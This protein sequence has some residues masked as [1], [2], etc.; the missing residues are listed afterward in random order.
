MAYVIK[1]EVAD[2][3]AKRFA[4]AAQK[5]MYGGKDIAVGDTLYIIAS[6]THGG[7]GL[8]AKGTVTAVDYSAVAKPDVSSPVYGGGPPEGRGGGKRYTPRVSI[9]VKRTATAKRALGRDTLRPH[10]GK[11]GGKGELAMRLYKQATDKIIGVSDVA[12]KVLE[13]CF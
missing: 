10:I 2:T 4:F 5:T 8:I 13:G 12:A 11:G 7:P 1:T 3:G 6:E 9:A